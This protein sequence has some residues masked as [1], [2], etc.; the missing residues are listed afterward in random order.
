MLKVTQFKRSSKDSNP[1]LTLHRGDIML[2]ERC[3]RKVKMCPGWCR[4]ERC[5]SRPISLPPDPAEKE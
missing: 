5:S 3:L 2:S 4:L 1:G